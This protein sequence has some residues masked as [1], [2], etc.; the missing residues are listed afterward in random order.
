MNNSGSTRAIKMIRP[1]AEPYGLYH[2][3]FSARALLTS[4]RNQFPTMPAAVNTATILRISTILL[5][6]PLTRF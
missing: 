3:A 1:G 5:I 6:A 2:G 4:E